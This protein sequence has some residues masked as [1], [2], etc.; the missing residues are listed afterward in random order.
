MDRF[1]T[2]EST[3]HVPTETAGSVIY[4]CGRGDIVAQSISVR[5]LYSAT[6]FYNLLITSILLLMLSYVTS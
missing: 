4:V 5:K 1:V 2:F 6:L 3:K